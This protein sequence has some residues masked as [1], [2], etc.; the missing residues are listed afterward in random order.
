MINILNENK[1]SSI[2]G[3]ERDFTRLSPGKIY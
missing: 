2:Y 1:H 3:G